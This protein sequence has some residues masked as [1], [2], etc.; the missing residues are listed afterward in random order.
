MFVLTFWSDIWLIMLSFSQITQLE[1][2][3]R[4]GGWHPILGGGGGGG[5]SNCA[6]ILEVWAQMEHS[7]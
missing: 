6:A 4:W 5:G 3:V 7:Q 1:E 2:L